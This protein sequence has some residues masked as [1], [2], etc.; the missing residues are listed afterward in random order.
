MDDQMFT[1]ID[2]IQDPVLLSL[3]NNNETDL[4]PVLDPKHKSP[5]LKKLDENVSNIHLDVVKTVNDSDVLF[6]ES[7][8]LLIFILLLAGLPQGNNLIASFMPKFIKGDIVITII[9]SL[10]LF[11]IYYIVSRFIL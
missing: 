1:N 8:I 5:N 6:N 10:M 3:N 9:K 7:N 2:D 4:D 11:L